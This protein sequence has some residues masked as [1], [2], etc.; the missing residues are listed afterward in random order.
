MLSAQYLMQCNYMNEGCDGGWSFFHGY[1]AENGH[2][3]D[4]ECA[5]YKART[6]GF[7]CGQYKNCSTK[8]KI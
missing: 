7:S 8:A 1:L 2:L 3:V 6:K 5:P 4:E